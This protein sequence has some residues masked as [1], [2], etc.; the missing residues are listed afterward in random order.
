MKTHLEIGA[1]APIENGIDPS[2]LM[3]CLGEEYDYSSPGSILAGVPMQKLNTHTIYQ[4]AVM[5]HP[6]TEIERTPI[7]TNRLLWMMSRARFQLAKHVKDD[8]IF[9]PSLKRAGALLREFQECGL[10]EDVTGI[11]GDQNADALA[12]QVYAVSQK[13]KEFETVMANEMPG[14]AIYSVFQHGIFST[15]DLIT[16]ADHHIPE[17]LRGPITDKA[18]KDIAEA[19]RC[20]AFE[21]PTAAAFHMWRALETV[22]DRYY[23]ALTG[24]SFEDANITRNWGEYI[25]AL[26]EVGAD[27]KIT[28]FLDHIRAEYRNPISHPSETLESDDAFTLFGTALSAI[29]QTSK[30]I[31]ATVPSTVDEDDEGAIA[32]GVLPELAI[33]PDT[34]KKKTAS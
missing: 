1:A 2:C 31:L 7:K 33:M 24:K 17:K 11:V 14:L 19:G 8:G 3:V 32:E 26:R 25:K 20:L 6:L 27:E 10:P 5:V 15:D 23:F 21:L 18:K 30:A 12:W 13:A 16:H 34:T 29:Q 4:L 22:M 9:S 28:V